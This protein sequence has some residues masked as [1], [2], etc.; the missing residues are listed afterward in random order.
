[1]INNP[2]PTRAEISDV[3][4]AVTDGS[5]CVMLSGETASGN[6]PMEAVAYMDSICKEAGMIPQ[7][8]HLVEGVESVGDYASM[9]EALKQESHLNSTRVC[10]SVERHVLT[11]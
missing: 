3:G 5:D 4:N 11:F 7:K 8:T 1:M 6:F 2:R 9:F 10:K